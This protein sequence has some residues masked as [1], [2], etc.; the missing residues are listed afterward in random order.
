MYW[1]SCVLSAFTTGG[2]KYATWAHLWNSTFHIRKQSTKI[3]LHM[4][5]RYRHSDLYCDITLCLAIKIETQQ[6]I[7]VKSV[8]DIVTNGPSS[9]GDEMAKIAS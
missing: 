1:A 9:P 3:N 5:C 6:K 7:G 8:P 2:G 4:S